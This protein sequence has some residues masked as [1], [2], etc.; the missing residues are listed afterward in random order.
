MSNSGPETSD[1][2]GRGFKP[3]L[4]GGHGV[5]FVLKTLYS[6]QKIAF[7]WNAILRYRGNREGLRSIE[8]S[9]SPVS[10]LGAPEPK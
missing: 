1:G 7:D 2:Q 10:F 3:A 4:P 6:L 9:G 8:A 5:H